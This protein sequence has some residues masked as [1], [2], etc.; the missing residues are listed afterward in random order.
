[1]ASSLNIGPKKVH[2]TTINYSSTVT[3]PIVFRDILVTGFT[4]QLLTRQILG[5]PY[6]AG[7]TATGDALREARNICD[8]SCRPFSDGAARSIVVLTDGYSNTG[9]AVQPEAQALAQITK[10]NVFA[11]GIGSAINKAELNVIAS[12]PQYVLQVADYVQLTQAIN[13]ITIFTC[14]MPVFVIINVK[15]ESEVSANNY[16]YYQMD[17]SSFMRHSNGQGIFVA[18]NTVI[19]KG[20]TRVFTSTTNTNPHEGINKESQARL[21]ANGSEQYYLEYVEP[22]VS[23]FYFSILGIDTISQYDFITNMF[24]LN[25]NTIG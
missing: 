8:T 5:L 6:L 11:V 13:N 24:D 1:M 17:T 20:R 3:V 2:I 22:G 21:S 23:T 25:G 16:R 4:I 12:K 9:V 15:V 14:D 18:I 19:H 7:A 10:A